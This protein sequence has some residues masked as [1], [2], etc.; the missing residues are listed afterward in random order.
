[1]NETRHELSK[2]Q[3]VCPECLDV[4][5]AVR[6]SYGNEV[7]LEKECPV[8][9]KFKT[10][11]WRGAPPFETWLRPKLPSKPP[12]TDGAVKLGCPYDCGLCEEH[13]QH[14][15]TA[16][17]E[18]TQRCNLHCAYCFASAG[19]ELQDL[20]I[21]DIK[22]QFERVIKDCK[23]SNLQLSGGEPT[24]RDDLPEIVA[25]ARK[26]GFNFIQV[27][28]NG[29]RIASDLEYLKA[30]R[31]AGLNSVFLQ[32]DGLDDQ[33]YQRLRGRPILNF[34]LQAI[35]NCA[36]QGIGVVL[37]P[38]IV[39]DVNDKAIGDIVKFAIQNI[40][41]VRGVHFQPVSF[42]G[43]YP[44]EPTARERITLPEVMR[45]IT[46]QTDGLIKLED[47]KPPCCENSLCSFQGNFKLWPDG[48]FKALAAS[49]CGP[50]DA[51]A[52]A[53]RTKSFVARQW[54][55]IGATVNSKSSASFSNSW[56]ELLYR[57]KTYSFSISG[58]AF[59]DAW[60]LDLE[61]LKD[62]CIHVV[63]P[64]GKL[65]PFCAYNLTSKNGQSLY[66]G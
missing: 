32:F 3:S 61:R 25:L 65:I 41:A 46:E 57:L 60:N 53:K 17:V 40:P 35:K 7:F 29:L 1:M 22:E 2:T 13:R 56:D 30:L 64:K 23:D 52:G 10:L 19:S 4:L 48:S 50:V 27:N 38:T 31:Q 9:G 62:C 15:C 16:L 33:I 12:V 6:V 47:L 43:R 55:G 51:E 11:L 36:E 39:R 14:T 20:P 45:G 8:H 59:Q 54:N 66:R 58:M 28:T 34:K 49:C 21:A 5:T 42:F 63:S 18:V 44:Q 24:V 37:V 26:T